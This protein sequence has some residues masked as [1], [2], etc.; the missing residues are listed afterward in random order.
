MYL[1]TATVLAAQSG[2]E[3]NGGD[4]GDSDITYEPYQKDE[5]APWMHDLRR[6][7]T[8]LIGSI[9]FT[10]FFANIGFDSH[11]YVSSGFDENYLPL[12]LGTSPAK[13]DMRNR[14]KFDR[15]YVSLSLSVSIAIADFVIGKIWDEK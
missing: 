1:C 6:F 10:F 14:T 4:G 15:L 12:F 3:S 2:S 7:E 8:I 9:P 13:E 11:A 5:F